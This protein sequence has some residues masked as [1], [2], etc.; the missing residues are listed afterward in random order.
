VYSRVKLVGWVIR[1]LLQVSCCESMLLDAGSWGTSTVR[2]P[3]I[4]GSSAVGS[5]YQ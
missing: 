1:E 3:R 2:E 4:R 5:R